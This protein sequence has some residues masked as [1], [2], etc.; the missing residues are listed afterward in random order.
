VPE[1]VPHVIDPRAAHA[2]VAE[3][4]T[5]LQTNADL[6]EAAFRD[7]FRSRPHA[8][9][10]IGPYTPLVNR[11]DL[12]AYEYPL[13]GDFRCDL[14]IGDS[15]TRACTFVELEDAGPR[16]LFV[17]HGEKSTR[18]WSPRFEHGFSQVVDWFYKLQDLTQTATMEARF[19]RRAIDYA[20]VLV[21]GRDQ[22]GAG[23]GTFFNHPDGWVVRRTLSSHA[24]SVDRRSTNGPEIR[25][26]L[27]PGSDPPGPGPRGRHGTR[28]D[29]R[30]TLRPRS[31]PPSGRRR[32]RSWPRS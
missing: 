15:V 25:D 12:I 22:Q 13:F 32:S 26:P 21:I 3:L 27:R 29:P 2:E 14:A 1:F 24:R 9:A 16:S 18:E 30:N 28:E 8:S 31:G 20:G 5:L 11:S 17:R 19:G 10:L 6:K 23:T 4:R 7:F